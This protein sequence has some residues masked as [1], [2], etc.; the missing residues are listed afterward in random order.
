MLLLSNF[1]HRLTT[2]DSH[3][4]LL[5]LTRHHMEKQIFKFRLKT[6]STQTSCKKNNDVRRRN[7]SRYLKNETKNEN[8]GNEDVKNDD[9][10]CV[11]KQK[12]NS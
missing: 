8:S 4:P 10:N 3:E 5:L 2:S 6:K 11:E 9:G 1:D 7:R 12:Y